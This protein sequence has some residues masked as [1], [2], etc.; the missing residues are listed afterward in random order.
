[1]RQEVMQKLLSPQRD[2]RMQAWSEL[3]SE[4][5]MSHGQI[6]Q[7]DR[8]LLHQVLLAEEDDDVRLHG[9]VMLVGFGCQPCNETTANDHKTPKRSPRSLDSWFLQL[10]EN[11]SSLFGT[12]EENFAR[13][14]EI[15]V[16][17]VA[18]RFPPERF[19]DTDIHSVPLADDASLQL[20]LEHDYET[21][22]I[23]GRLSLFGDKA[24][25]LLKGENLRFE[26]P[27]MERPPNLPRGSLDSDYH[28]VCER[29][30]NQ[31]PFF[32]RASETN[33]IR[34]DYGLVQVYP[35]YNGRRWMTVVQCAGCSALGTLGSARWLA[36]D[37]ARRQD[38]GEAAYSCTTGNRM[39]EPHGSACQSSSPFHHA[40][41]ATATHRV[42][43]TF[44]R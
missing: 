6:S 17:H 23:M 32:H 2:D 21:V 19:P 36:Y 8:K 1:M 34:T 38:T 28:C 29:D 44:C 7:A 4:P 14:D 12:T 41:L 22:L 39:P 24:A 3:H 33:G 43:A 15:A 30:G 10:F 18:R 5:E 37:L 25:R 35:A 16:A 13:R 9:I 27:E 40:R 11:P 42:A 20:L 26:F 31:K